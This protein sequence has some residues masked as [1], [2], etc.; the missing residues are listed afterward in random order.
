MLWILKTSIRLISRYKSTSFLSHKT[1]SISRNN[2][3]HALS[4]DGKDE[5]REG[6]KGWKKN[7]SSKMILDFLD[8]NGDTL[9]DRPQLRKE[10]RIYISDSRNSQRHFHDIYSP[11][12]EVISFWFLWKVCNDS[13]VTAHMSTRAHGNGF[14]KN[15]LHAIERR[16]IWLDIFLRDVIFHRPFSM[17]GEEIFDLRNLIRVDW[18]EAG[19]VP[20]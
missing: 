15:L 11:C 3:S 4:A 12:F 16:L 20:S 8:K 19:I 6:E 10:Y 18:Q 14:T 7:P 9:R 17:A 1:N 5:N 13:C 2:D